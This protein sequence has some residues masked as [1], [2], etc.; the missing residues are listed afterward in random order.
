M[1]FGVPRPSQ[2]HGLDAVEHWTRIPGF[3]FKRGHRVIPDPQH[4]KKDYI[5]TFGGGVWYGS[6]DG[7][8]R[9]LDIMTPQVTAGT[10]RADLT[11]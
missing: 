9:P 8:D 2:G 3:N 6:V 10:L 5:T 1:R 4:P 11:A 7:E